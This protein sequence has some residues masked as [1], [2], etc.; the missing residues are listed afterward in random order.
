VTSIGVFRLGNG[1]FVSALLPDVCVTPE[2]YMVVFLYI[3]FASRYT[4][5]VVIVDKINIG[6]PSERRLNTAT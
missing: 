2:V 1:I 4:L 3:L 5:V 6:A